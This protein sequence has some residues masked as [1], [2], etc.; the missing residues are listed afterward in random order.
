MN[1]NSCVVPGARAALFFAAATVMLFCAPLDAASTPGKKPAAG[2]LY[3]T[4]YRQ[5]G[6]SSGPSPFDNA[7]VDG[8][9]LRTSW[10][11]TETA[12]NVY[13]WAQIDQNM[14]DANRTGK[15]FALGVVSG[16]RSPGWFL[17]SGAKTITVS[18]DRNYAEQRQITMP[19]P[20]DRD[21]QTEWGEFLETVAQRYD[22]EPNLGYVLISGLGQAFEPFMA[23]SPD[24]LRK[25][26]E[27]GG[28]PRWIEGSKAVIDL[29]AVHFERTPF[30]LTM[31]YP[32]PSPEGS[33]AIKEVV[34]Y[35]LRKYPGRFGVKYDGLDA[36]ARTQ[37]VFHR[38][39]SE[40]STKTPVGYQMI[41]SST[42]FNAG[43]LKGGLD[44]V[45]NAGIAMKAHFI[46]VYAVDCDASKYAAL[47]KTTSTALKRNQALLR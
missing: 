13:D 30:I 33:Q 40:S 45:L 16:F 7:A 18:F 27:M 12:N 46:E 8:V 4:D 43:M 2:I 10:A 28:L 47:L 17:K 11:L 5:N 38:V 3:L 34:N 32:V 29:Y 36:Q 6:G 41:W 21:F 15:I 25:F 20:W 35:G 39:I 24:D 1:T 22:G 9:I 31:H 37:N 26:N 44:E 19:V 42:G 23:K 14:Q